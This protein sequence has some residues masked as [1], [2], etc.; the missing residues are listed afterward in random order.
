MTVLLQITTVDICLIV[1]DFVKFS[2]CLKSTQPFLIKLGLL[3][4]GF[5]KFQ[6]PFYAFQVK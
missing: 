2:F 3:L 4:D 5:V 1:V 6:Q